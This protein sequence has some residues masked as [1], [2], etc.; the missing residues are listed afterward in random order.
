MNIVA[1]QPE[2]PGSTNKDVHT[3]EFTVAQL[4][5]IPRLRV[6]VATAIDTYLLTRESL[7]QHATRYVK[8]ILTKKA[9]TYVLQIYTKR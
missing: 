4:G 7:E 1:E 5:G 6:F 2:P 8:K 9:K 3:Y